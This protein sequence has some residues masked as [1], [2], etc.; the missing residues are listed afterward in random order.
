M[1]SRGRGPLFIRG[2]WLVYGL[3]LI[4]S[5]GMM[6]TSNT[7]LARTVRDDVN[8]ILNP[9]EIAINDATDRVS[10]IVGAYWSTLIQVDS[11]R[12]DNERL[13]AENKKLND[14]LSRM[15]DISQLWTDFTRISEANQ[16]SQYQNLIGRVVVRNIS[17]VT[18]KTLIINRGLADGVR[19]GMVVMDDGGALV[20]RVLKVE[21]YDSTILLVNDPSAVVIGREADTG[22]MGTVQ[23]EVGG[24]LTMDYVDSASK[25]KVGQ[26][27]TTAGLSL[28]QSDVRSPYPPGLLIG[29]ILSVSSDRNEV[30]QSATLQPAADLNNIN[31]VLVIMNYQG[32]F[33]TPAPL[34]SGATPSP[35]PSPSGSAGPVKPTPT[36]APP[37]PTPTPGP[38]PVPTPPVITPPP[39]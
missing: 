31:W 28:P 7:R 39:H 24:L 14:E 5:V 3:L 21:N 9:V 12:N 11:L 33:G 38:T 18:L 16:N 10:G 23:G 30:V 26:A 2:Q 15:Q 32:G 25:L 20:G 29:K 8:L 36:P 19:V 27:V 34:P 4:V 37:R 22:A 6:G 1:F 17:D 35:S 13:K